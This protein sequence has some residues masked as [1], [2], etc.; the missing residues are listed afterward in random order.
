MDISVF[1]GR[2]SLLGGDSGYQSE[3]R[4]IDDGGFFGASL[5]AKVVDALL[6]AGL[7]RLVMWMDRPSW[8]SAFPGR[9]QLSR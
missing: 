1:R 5:A 3:G 2:F 8:G 7:G 4:W 9:R 6:Q